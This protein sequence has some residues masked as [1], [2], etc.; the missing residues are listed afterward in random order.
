MTIETFET[1]PSIA[2]AARLAWAAVVRDDTGQPIA[3]TSGHDTEQDAITA[4]TQ[5]TAA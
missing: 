4:V 5:Q 2:E 1:A 3:A